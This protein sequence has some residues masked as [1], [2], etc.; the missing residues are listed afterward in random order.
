[1]LG[2]VLGTDEDIDVAPGPHTS[3][4]VLF[5]WSLSPVVSAIVSIDKYIFPQR[6]SSP[7]ECFERLVHVNVVGRREN[8]ATRVVGV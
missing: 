4:P 7:P 5:R 6:R 8:G 2:Y 1:M 3:Y